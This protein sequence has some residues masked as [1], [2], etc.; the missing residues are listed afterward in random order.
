MS[1]DAELD[2][3][4][5]SPLG[6]FTRRRNELAKA[7]SK[8]GDR[9]AAAEVKGLGKPSIPAW[10]VNQLVRRERLQLRSLL[11]ASDRVR[12]AQER[13]FRGGDAEELRDAAARQREV[14]DALVGSAGDLLRSAGQTASEETLERVRKTLTAVASDDDGRRLVEAGRLVHDLEPA[15][16]GVLAPAGPEAA[17]P[18]G[19]AGDARKRRLEEAQAKLAAAQAEAADAGERVKQAKAEA[20]KAERAADAARRALAEA[21]SRLERLAGRVEAAQKEL[22]RAR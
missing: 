11:A 17:K 5:G 12:E 4:Y 15:G 2:R 1:L 6:D 9:D 7:L 16:F 8:A 13:L 22:D 18:S 3:L 20:R 10:A 14:V 21:E 19:R